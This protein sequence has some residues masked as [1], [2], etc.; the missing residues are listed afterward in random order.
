[1]TH[2]QRSNRAGGRAAAWSLLL[3]AGLC[4][5]SCASYPLEGLRA[6]RGSQLRLANITAPVESRGNLEM[7]SLAR[8]RDFAPAKLRKAYILIQTNRAKE[9]IPLLTILLGSGSPSV[10]GY[11]YYMRSLAYQKMQN[12]EKALSDARRAKAMAISPDLITP[13]AGM[14][15]KL[16]RSADATTDA[17]VAY[18]FQILPRRAWGAQ[19][20]SPRNMQ[21]MGQIHRLTIHHTAMASYDSSKNANATSIRS[22]QIGHIQREGWADIGYHY[23]IDQAGRIW[24]GREDEWQGAHAGG[25]MNRGN[26]GICLLGNFSRRVQSPSKQQ[27]QSLQQLV[28]QT[29][30]RHGIP[31]NRIFTHRE[32]KPSTECPGD[33]L[34]AEVEQ[35]RRQLV[36]GYAADISLA[37]RPYR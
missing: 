8:D 24:K 3:F 15:A 16:E 30:R 13:A 5:T 31:G 4:L 20:A 25:Q 23:L 17:Q 12:E 27:L 22:I 14:L 6:R 28:V 21:R 1:M 2:H 33:L 11:T 26:L 36:R 10:D 37:R 18:A 7:Q 29:C 32:M 34:Q 19:S 35:M 9:A